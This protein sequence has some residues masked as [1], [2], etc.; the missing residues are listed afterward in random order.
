MRTKLVIPWPLFFDSLE[1]Q[2]VRQRQQWLR[3]WLFD[4]CGLRRVPKVLMPQGELP[5]GI[6]L[7]LREKQERAVLAVPAGRKRA[8]FLH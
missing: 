7:S 3:W 2:P 8:G 5:P 4:H 1:K 6:L